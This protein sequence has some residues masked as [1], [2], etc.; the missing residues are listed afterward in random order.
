MFNF[1]SVLTSGPSR[2]PVTDFPTIEGGPTGSPVTDAPT[3]GIATS[4]PTVSSVLT[5]E[6]GRTPGRDL[7]WWP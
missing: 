4:N 7:Q 6:I 2:S 1:I 5:S 3:S